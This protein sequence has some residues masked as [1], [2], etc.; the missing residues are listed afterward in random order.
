MFTRNAISGKHFISILQ[1]FHYTVNP[2]LVA[3]YNF[4]TWDSYSVVSEGVYVHLE[5]LHLG[6]QLL[7]LRLKLL[8]LFTAVAAF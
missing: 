1:L 2:F 4:P 3:E 5:L 6:L 7:H 8:H